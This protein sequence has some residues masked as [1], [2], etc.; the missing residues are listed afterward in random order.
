[1]T[2]AVAL[3]L[4]AAGCSNDGTGD[5]GSDAGPS[6]STT[7]PREAQPS[8]TTGPIK[9]AALAAGSVIVSRTTRSGGAEG[10][11]TQ[12]EIEVELTEPMSGRVLHVGEE[13]WTLDI[14][15]G[16]GYLKDQTEKKSTNRWTRLSGAETTKRLEDVT[17]DGLLGVLDDASAITKTEPATVGGVAATCHSLTLRPDPD[18][19]EGPVPQS[20]RVCVDG[21]RRPVELLVI[22]DADVTTSVFTQWGVAVEAMAPPPNLV[23]AD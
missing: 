16:V 20:A 3:T 18:V 5:D 6:T 1:M 19:D 7:K 15:A 9:D 14:V 12:E 22:A 17:L 13:I 4:V 21:D 10:G 8:D 2:G 11:I 23:D